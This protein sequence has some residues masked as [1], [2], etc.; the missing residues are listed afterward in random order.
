MHRHL[1]ALLLSLLITTLL[2]ACG[3]STLIDSYKAESL[4]RFPAESVVIKSNGVSH[5]F[6]VMIA[7]TDIRRSRGLM[8]TEQLEADNGMLFLF[9]TPIRPAMWMKNTEIPLDFLFI[10]NGGKVVYM[11]CNQ[12]PESTHT[13]QPDV[14]VIG[15]M[16]LPGGTVE[17]LHLETGAVVY[18]RHFHHRSNTPLSPSTPSSQ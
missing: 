5:T 17:R 13:I 16:E 14:E 2:T 11:A 12:T 1:L 4:Y 10:A 9:D 7:D 15:V 6:A 18:Q 3:M 8:Y